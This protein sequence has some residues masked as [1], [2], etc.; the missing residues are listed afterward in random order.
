MTPGMYSVV[1]GLT[2]R[3]AQQ[4]MIAENISGASML[5]HKRRVGGFA[6]FDTV[7]D[8]VKSGSQSQLPTALTQNEATAFDWSL[9]PLRKTEQPL[10]LALK[11]PGFF[12]VQTSAGPRLTRDGHFTVNSEYQV[13]NDAGYPLLGN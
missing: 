3:A 12:T 5:G 11:G 1:S 10:D 2:A 6:A 13:V 8:D 4:E 7:L 9:G